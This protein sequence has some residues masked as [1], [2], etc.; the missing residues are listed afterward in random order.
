MKK[1]ICLIMALMMI[2]ALGAC[3]P[4]QGAIADIG[5]Q[6]GETVSLT[7]DVQLSVTPLAPDRYCSVGEY[8]TI[9]AAAMKLFKETAALSEDE[10][11][12]ISPVSILTALAMTAQ[13]AEAE[14]LA[15]FEEFFGKEVGFFTTLMTDY[16][17]T[18]TMHNETAK[19]SLANSVW[20]RDDAERLTVEEDFLAR[21]NTMRAEVF[22]SA[23]NDGTV[24]DV[25]KWVKENT[26]GMID[27]IMEKVN[28]DDVIYLINALAFDNE[29]ERKY[30][31]S[32]VGTW[33]F[34]TADGNEQKAEFMYSGESV[35]LKDDK[36]TG[37]IK[38]YKDDF[39][40][41]AILPDEGVSVDEY[42][43]GMDENTLANLVE[44]GKDVYMVRAGL[45]KFDN[46]M[47]M[48]MVDVLK[49][50]GLT[51]MFDSSAA[52]F[53]SMATSTRGNIFISKVA[54]KTFI[55]VDTKGTR[56]AAVTQVVASDGAA[57]VMEEVILNRPFIYMIVDDYANE[58]LP[59]FI[60]TVENMK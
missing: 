7:A 1:I 21:C 16:A 6:S 28:D 31:S 51:E 32:D 50:L 42:I 47:S 55:E 4:E 58:S 37:F 33:V 43:A 52:D 39:S 2:F 54:H 44:G 18:I 45:P 30:E 35:Y 10:N 20:V 22:K 12:L 53:G 5:G 17:D 60:G 46:E 26:D 57:M 8:E 59:L 36:A 15:Q 9:R 56:A 14:T 3:G 11:L 49:A 27:S 41:V 19:V 25:N 34:R 24:R 40:F 38:P 29:W 23:F 48:D 13:G